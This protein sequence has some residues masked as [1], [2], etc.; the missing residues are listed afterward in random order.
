MYLVLEISLID[1]MATPDS[2][3]E[4]EDLGEGCIFQGEP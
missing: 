2:L 4:I 3:Y 1:H